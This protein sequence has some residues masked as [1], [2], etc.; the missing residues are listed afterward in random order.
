MLYPLIGAHVT[1]ATPNVD[2]S[3]EQLWIEV[4]DKKNVNQMKAFKKQEAM[5]DELISKNQVDSIVDYRPKSC[6]FNLVIRKSQHL[7]NWIPDSIV[8]APNGAVAV[9]YNKTKTN[10]KN[11]NQSFTEQR[12]QEFIDKSKK[13]YEE[14]QQQKLQQIRDS[15]DSE[16]PPKSPKKAES[17]NLELYLGPFTMCDWIQGN[18]AGKTEQD[19]SAFQQI[20]KASQE[21]ETNVGTFYQICVRQYERT[22]GYHALGYAMCIKWFWTCLFAAWLIMHPHLL[23][24]NKEKQYI[25]EN[26]T[27]NIKYIRMY[28]HIIFT[29]NMYN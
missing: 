21:Q 6:D 14:K 8:W 7:V 9:K 26:I 10:A 13:V 16:T 24:Q 22:R 27:G 11:H 4:K 5:I 28:L 19:V 18:T 1:M 15:N 17:R 25:N 20:I 23:K 2:P 29:L 3:V 12:K